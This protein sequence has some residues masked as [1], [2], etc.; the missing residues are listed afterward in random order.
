MCSLLQI[1]NLQEDT[2]KKDREGTVLL[3]TWVL[4]HYKIPTEPTS[5][6]V[7]VWRKLKRLG[8]VLLHDAVWVLPSTPSTQEQFQW[9][10]AEIVE[11]GGD[12]L[13]WQAQLVSGAS[14][15]ELVQRFTAQVDAEYHEI[16]SDVEGHVP[17]LIALSRRY[18]QTRL[19]DYFQSA[20]GRQAR[21]ALVEAREKV[22]EAF[23]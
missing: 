2:D 21:D 14:E 3:H 23:Q 19:E 11:M 18:Q 7:Y 10:A 20:L 15:D 13:L 6:R 9:L 17:D 1:Y 12:A 4:L 16:L 22:K 8:A 5:R